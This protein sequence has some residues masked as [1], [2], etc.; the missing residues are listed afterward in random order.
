MKAH[1]KET[2]LKGN[3]EI[4]AECH[5]TRQSISFSKK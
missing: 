4:F 2:F 3:N 5:G 1:G